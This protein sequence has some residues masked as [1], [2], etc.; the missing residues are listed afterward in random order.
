[1][2]RLP[3]L[4]LLLG[5][6]LQAAEPS[7][8][9]DAWVD[10]ITAEVDADQAMSVMRQ[11][12]ETDRWFTFPKFEETARNLSRTMEN[13]GLRQV[14]IVNPPADGKSQFGYWTMP[15]AWDATQA[16]LEIV[17]PEPDPQFRVLANFQRT[18]TSLG[19]WSGSTPPG[20]V[21]AEIVDVGD[22][23]ENAIAKMDLAGKLA[24]TSRNPAGLKWALVKAKAVGAINAFSENAEGLPDDR[25]WINAWGDAGWAYTKASTPLLVFS[26]TPR[27]AAYVRKLLAE[28]GKV[29]ARAVVNARYYEG[30]YPYVTGVIPG[31]EQDGEEVLTVGHMAEQGA[32]DNATGVAAMVEALGALDRLIE[33][34]KLPRP[35]RTIR[36][37]VV[38]ELYGTMHY[39]AANPDRVA[40]TVGAMCLDTPAGPYEAAGTEYTFH[41][42]PDVARSYT[43]ALVLQVASSYFD[44]KRPGRP[45][46]WAPYSTGTDNFLGEPEIGIPT[47]WP[48]S[49]SGVHSHHNSADTP[50][51][52]DERSLRDLTVVTAAYLYALASAG[53]DEAMWLADAGLTRGYE[54][55]LQAYEEAFAGVA[56]AKPGEELAH[57][58]DRGLRLI[59]YRAGRER[60]AIESVDRLAPDGRREQTHAAADELAGR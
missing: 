56:K 3:A 4:A 20:G 34:G 31:A 6:S 11:T 35:R 32:H 14:E 21:R 1:M 40:R 39:L 57:A 25:Q 37:L 42:N 8:D 2:R 13:A 48:Y 12:W 22:A 30:G 54:G 33:A 45:W 26:I 36:M 41:M 18:P 38:G 59:D 49:G 52:V 60:Q 5:V 47:A 29:I 10:A 46:H 28:R 44:R 51:T 55:V 17:E 16:R 43:D 7:V 19:M 53:E 24:L 27:Q 15:L 23:G 50:D 9:L 58:L